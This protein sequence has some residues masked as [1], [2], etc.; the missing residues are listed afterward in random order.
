MWWNWSR[1]NL[2]IIFVLCNFHVWKLLGD[3]KKW[4]SVFYFIYEAVNIQW[5]ILWPH[6]NNSSFFFIEFEKDLISSSIQVTV[7]I[8]MQIVENGAMAHQF[9]K[10][11]SFNGLF[12]CSI[13]ATNWLA[14][15]Q[16]LVTHNIMCFPF[17]VVF[18][19]LTDGFVFLVFQRFVWLGAFS[20]R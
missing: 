2:Y 19:L 10:L 14:R 11:F 8:L 16:T 12:W 7:V 5:N 6:I 17:W 20:P 4:L 18:F 13:S 15:F 1:K 3:I 9:L